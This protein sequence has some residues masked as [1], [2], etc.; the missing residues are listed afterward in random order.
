MRLAVGVFLHKLGNDLI[1][2]QD[3]LITNA[4]SMIV[5]NIVL[6]G[7]VQCR[8]F[9]WVGRTTLPSKVFLKRAEVVVASVVLLVIW[10]HSF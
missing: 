8:L 10:S 1:V 6:I 7:F 9:V 2:E 5:P 4:S 3:L